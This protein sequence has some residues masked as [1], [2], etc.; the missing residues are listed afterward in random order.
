MNAARLLEHFEQISDA[1]DAVPRL[2]RFVRSLAVRGLLSA[3]MPNNDQTTAPRDADE[4]ATGSRPWQLPPQWSWTMVADTADYRFGK[5]LDKA[6]NRGAPKRYL[7]NV[8]VRWFDFDLSDVLEMLFEEAE[9]PEY[10]LRRGDVLICEGGEPGR[11]AVWDE[12]EPGILFQKAIH[13]VRFSPAVLPEFFL[14]ALKDAAD[15]TRLAALFTGVT[16]KHLTGKGLGLFTFPLPPLAEQQRIV[17]KVDELMALCD[18]MEAAQVER[19]ARRDR[20]V[21][22]SL[23]RVTQPPAADVASDARAAGFH[24]DHFA[25]LTTRPEHVKHLRQT[26]LNLAVRGRLVPQDP[27]D[28]SA[29]TLLDLIASP[30]TSTKSGRPKDRSDGISAPPYSLPNSWAWTPFGSLIVAS[31]SGW[32]PKTEG[33]PRIDTN[34]GVLKV[35]AVSWDVFLAE[36]NKQLLPGVTPPERAVVNPGDFLISRANTSDLIAKCVVV[37]QCPPRLIMSDKIVRLTLSDHVEKRFLFIVNNYAD[38]ARRHYAENA[39]GTSLSMKNVSRDV[40]YSLPIPL[41]PLAEQRRI[42]AKVDELMT[43]CDQL[44]ASLA[45]AATDRARLLESLLH[46]ALAPAA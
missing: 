21:A 40:I 9:L 24:L 6:K 37:E 10:A 22:A 28:E 20:L 36:E 19:E 30:S 33:F 43:L 35:S 44:E 25:R 23:A 14:I 38:H 31:D 18:R 26:I 41:P 12:R 8:N 5:M 7:R 42:V 29:D 1:A 32:S 34:W 11:A 2:R 4:A 45:A 39:T 13:R 17:A 46:E 15:S 27:A 16:I 3:R